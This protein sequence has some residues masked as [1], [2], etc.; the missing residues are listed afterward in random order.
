[1]GFH[2]HDIV[3]SSN[4]TPFFANYASSKGGSIETVETPLD[5]PLGRGSSPQVVGGAGKL[6]K[7]RVRWQAVPMQRVG[8]GQSRQPGGGGGARS[9]S[10][11]SGSFPRVDQCK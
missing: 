4:H 2:A 7:G 11:V 9:S 10:F 3:H 6:P 5:T 1:M 8:T